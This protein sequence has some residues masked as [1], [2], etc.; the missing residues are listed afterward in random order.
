MVLMNLAFLRDGRRRE[1]GKQ[2]DESPDDNR[3]TAPMALNSKGFTDALSAFLVSYPPLLSIFLKLD[4]YFLSF[5]SQLKD[6][7][8]QALKRQIRT[9]HA[10]LRH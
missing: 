9:V 1:G 3:L 6:K 2:T 5:V 4:I 8:C 7:T 10:E